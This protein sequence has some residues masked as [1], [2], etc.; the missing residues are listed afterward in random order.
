MLKKQKDRYLRRGFWS[1]RAQRMWPDG[2]NHSTQTRAA[3]MK[4]VHDWN[5][6]D[7]ALTHIRGWVIKLQDQDRLLSHTSHLALRTLALYTCPHTQIHTQLGTIGRQCLRL[8][9][10]AFSTQ[11]CCPHNVWP[12]VLCDDARESCSQLSTPT[13]SYLKRDLITGDR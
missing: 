5:I 7:T 12:L 10:S 8:M 9:L 11:H 4:L 2:V 1:T 13:A 3:F 6:G